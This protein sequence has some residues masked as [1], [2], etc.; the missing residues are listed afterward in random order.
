M[1]GVASWRLT[2]PGTPT[3]LGLCVALF[4]FGVLAAGLVPNRARAFEAIDG[5]FE[6]HGY[7][8][9]QLRT[10]SRNFG[11][12]WDLTQ[13]YNV[14]NLELE[15]DLVQNTHGILDL[16]EVY[17]RIEARYDCI[18][19][20]G[21]GM[22]DGVDV[23]GN[24]AKNLP[25]RLNSGNEYT[26]A[27]SIFISND[28]P[29]GRNSEALRFAD[30]A[31]L[32]ERA[33]RGLSGPLQ[34]PYTIRTVPGFGG[35]YQGTPE[36]LGTLNYPQL[37][38]CQGASVIGTGGSAF[39]PDG[40]KKFIAGRVGARF[41]DADRNRRREGP[42]PSG[43]PN[44]G[45]PVDD[46]TEGAPYLIAM[47]PFQNFTFTSI[48]QIG[49]SSNGFPSLLMGPWSPENFVSTNATLAGLPN[50]L[51][52]SRVSPQSLNSGF[53]ANPMRPIPIFRE[54]NPG[55]REIY[56][57][58]E[59]ELVDNRDPGP[60]RW[61]TINPVS[62]QFGDTREWNNRAARP[63]E[64]R[65]LF[66]PSRP[67]RER[68]ASGGFGEYPFNISE[69]DR[70]FNR[71]AS[72]Q[73]E[74]ELKEAYV[75]LEMFDSRLW[76]RA[77][78]QSIV[79]GKTELFRTTDQFNPQD[80][81]LATLPSLEESRIALWSMRGVWSFYEVGPFSDVRLELAFNFE[82]ADL[83]ACGEPYAVNLVCALTFGSWAH[84][85]TGLGVAGIVQP[86]DPWDDS[87]GLEF[88]AR[89][90]WR[91]DRFS[92]AITDFYGY[93]DFPYTVRLSTYNRNVDWRSGR[94]R[95]YMQTPEQLANYAAYG[96]DTP[97][98]RGVVHPLSGG[99]PDYTRNPTGAGARITYNRAN[100]AG[101][102]TPGA[103]N[104]Q[105]SFPDRIDSAGNTTGILAENGV[106]Y[107]V[108]SDP[109]I[110]NSG[111]PTVDNSL[112]LMAGGWLNDTARSDPDPDEPRRKYSQAKIANPTSFTDW[113][114]GPQAHYC[115][116]PRFAGHAYCD[117]SEPGSRG[118]RIFDPQKF[119]DLGVPGAPEW[120]PN[121]RYNPY[122]DPRF[123][124]HF[125]VGDYDPDTVNLAS[126]DPQL[127]FARHANPGN[128]IASTP[129]LFDPFRALSD[130]PLKD[131]SRNFGAMWWGNAY[132]P[133]LEEYDPRNAL[134]NHPVNVSLF[135]F[136]CATTVGF[137]RLDASACALTVFSSSKQPSGADPGNPRISTLI[138][139]FL[140]GNGAFTG[141]L[142]SQPS[143]KILSYGSLLP[144]GMG[145]PLVQIDVDL[146]A[147]DRDGGANLCG[148]SLKRGCGKD[149]FR[150]TDVRRH[151]ADRLVNNPALNNPEDI[152]YPW[153]YSREGESYNCL[154]PNPIQNSNKGLVLC[155]G[156]AMGTFPGPRT[157]SLVDRLAAA[158][159]DSF[160]VT[161][162]LDR[163]LSPEQ[164]ALLGC[165]PFFGGSCGANGADLMWAEASAILQSFVGSDSLGISFADLGI[166]AL[167]SQSF[168]ERLMDNGSAAIEYRT[169]SRV[170]GKNGR[171]LR[172]DPGQ[173][174]QVQS[175]AEWIADV[176]AG[177][178]RFFAPWSD[179]PAARSPALGSNGYLVD[180]NPNLFDPSAT[181]S[182]PCSLVAGRL[183]DANG[184][185]EPGQ[186]R[187]SARCWDLRD[188]YRAYGVQ[189]GTATFEILGLGAPHCTTADIGGPAGAA[190]ILPGCRSKW[191]SILYQPLD[192]WDG[193]SPL[194]PNNPDAGYIGNN[195]YG[196][197]MSYKAAAA[198]DPGDGSRLNPRTDYR[199]WSS[200]PTAY[201]AN[202]NSLAAEVGCGTG[203]PDDV[204]NYD[205]YL[206]NP[207]STRSGLSALPRG[208][209]VRLD[210]AWGPSDLRRRAAEAS[211][212]S[213][214]NWGV[215]G[216]GG[217]Y[218]PCDPSLYASESQMRNDPD[219]YLGA[220][221]Q[222]VDGDPDRMGL[223]S[224]EG[225]LYPELAQALGSEAGNPL[226]A[227]LLYGQ[228]A[229]GGCTPGSS[230]IYIQ[231][232]A[233]GDLLPPA[234]CAQV[235][236]NRAAPSEPAFPATPAQ[237]AQYNN[238][239]DLFNQVSG[240]AGH[241][242]TGESFANEM[243][244]VSFNLLMLLVTFSPEFS[245]GL[246]SVRGFVNPEIY[247]HRYIYDEEWMWN[248]ECDGLVKTAEECGGRL[249]V[250]VSD[251]PG[252]G[253]GKYSA[254]GAT[255]ADPTTLGLPG[256]GQ[257]TLDSRTG[258]VRMVSGWRSLGITNMA[259]EADRAA[260][261][262][263]PLPAGVQNKLQRDPSLAN[264]LTTF[265]DLLMRECTSA[266]INTDPNKSAAELYAECGTP[267][268]GGANDWTLNPATGKPW[269]ELRLGGYTEGFPDG[270]L[271]ES[272]QWDYAF[273]G[274][275]NELMAM[276]PYCED[277][278]NT[279]RHIFE[280]QS[281][282]WGGTAGAGLW[283]FNRM[284][285]SR[286][287]AGETLGKERCTFVTPQYCS[288]VQALS[289]IAGQ[290]R[291]T[292]RAGGN[293]NFGRRTMQWQSGS[294]IYLGYNRRNVL[295][296]SMDFAEDVTK[297]NWS[298]EFT[299][300]EGIPFTDS[301]SYD[302]VT[303]ADDFNLT[304]S[305]DRPTFI[306]FLNAN[307]TFFFNS[308]WFFQYR[309]G[310][311]ES[312][313]SNG[314]W[315]V[316]ATFAVFTGY[317]QDRLNPTVVFVWDFGSSSGGFLPQVNYRF[318][319]NFS[320]TVGA[321]VFMGEQGLTNMGVNT[322]GPA[323]PRSGPNAYMDGTTPGL[324]VVR[325]RDEVFMTLRYTF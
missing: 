116:D 153:I 219:C 73:D 74:G 186:D 211:L 185:L 194:Q 297:S 220:W 157:E 132:D 177:T 263:N 252:G 137:N 277:L 228:R 143:D 141:F 62:G 114:E 18:Y 239:L 210:A 189:P 305:V 40:G 283:G 258:R 92:F 278:P 166:G 107:R 193:V 237:I 68:L 213:G 172:I 173:L 301:D 207:D 148:A 187:A 284:D 41:W 65:G 314:P 160:N 302:L 192:S 106:P 179:D 196:Q 175:Q 144:N 162:A 215:F 279:Q 12:Q 64:A 58:Q 88:G 119:V 53:G 285:C 298:M 317:F 69:S 66:V 221:Q 91:W 127:E 50:P 287:L 315:N 159:R 90:E 35:I 254:Y 223:N 268:N 265:P 271:L 303:E 115:S 39:C 63:D 117:D 229:E 75:D 129:V 113:E 22:F 96:C 225:L 111:A 313:T 4:A 118:R 243:A 134:D 230:W 242:F 67:L 197:V 98:G 101:C 217:P 165:G 261:I 154:G 256:T 61:E 249:F 233:A 79:W 147:A 218:S 135:N 222:G 257:T 133:T 105:I 151:W 161:F 181:P 139:N 108:P 6:A 188:Y 198:F 2:R 203:D 294:E 293:E 244:G 310:Y 246:A 27:G 36:G 112:K 89:L 276:I 158:P 51:D 204:A 140:G 209:A 8:E 48:P 44:G 296:F 104:R 299:W 178:Q 126:A 205:C 156:L 32:E 323:S 42:N 275:E 14:F 199:Q 324:S 128:S 240:G 20:H 60:G 216:G 248:P 82:S 288:I 190:G 49:G 34:D 273:T 235:Y 24:D 13:W 281:D 85:I 149:A 307:R 322:I 321:S 26:H 206:F 155:G 319:E 99:Q 247:E 125:D 56:I 110:I 260:H 180:G 270:G 97:D 250:E 95:H 232:T 146:A 202:T 300:I 23:Y 57:R 123:D 25:P 38:R 169:D 163:A 226:A 71:G 150:T 174:I 291:N 16:M 282:A 17:V 70:A 231:R 46:G 167:V 274:G 164:E 29:R 83:G 124:K 325:D 266:R 103:T 214:L 109:E 272:L 191:A 200:D 136:I 316:L 234:E 78:K 269:Q 11:G 76:I 224:N 292:V 80:F 212:R 286:G 10:I 54:D 3:R 45:A 84:G 264:I 253:Q 309:K 93:D 102:L 295:G 131:R 245:D 122:Y 28:G 176:Q 30:A 15:L 308:Q 170:V 171:L 255:N 312:F 94:P 142:G 184:N 195:W 1:N 238:A 19:S 320:M 59:S 289:G 120:V 138:S 43:S 77:G 183:L 86:P 259:D 168:G 7:F 81:A 208:V 304:V 227:I 262:P 251:T 87:D 318:S 37:M 72:Q 280:I 145:I 290:K 100:E 55:Q 21:C 9:M 201:A 52:Q 31:T 130:I 33:Q 121:P 47:E 306:N 241:P 5:R 236:R 182:A 152:A 311:R 267:D